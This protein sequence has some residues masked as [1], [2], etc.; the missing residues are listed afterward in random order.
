M[1]FYQKFAH[2][3][4]KLATEQSRLL[5][6]SDERAQQRFLFCARVVEGG[7]PFGEWRCDQSLPSQISLDW[8]DRVVIARAPPTRGVR[9][10]VTRV[11]FFSFVSYALVTWDFSSLLKKIL[12][13]KNF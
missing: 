10:I 12:I 7:E 1:L 8:D 6:G 11:V 3:F 9:A 5:F 13:L 4:I 2:Y